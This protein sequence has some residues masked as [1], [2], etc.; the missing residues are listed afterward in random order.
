M[1]K[2]VFLSVVLVMMLALVAP[3]AVTVAQEKTKIDVWIAFQD[4]RLDWAKGVADKFNQMFP[5]YEVVVTGGYSYE[6]VFAQVAVAAEQGQL[7]AVVQFFEAG[8]QDARDSGLFKPI[9][10]ALGDRTEI[11]G[12]PV[13]FDDFVEP[14]RAYY[15]LDGK[16]TSMPWNTSSAIM[17]SNMNYLRAAGWE[18]PPATWDEV[19]AACEAIMALDNPPEYCFTWPNHGW[20]FEQW[21]AQQD[22]LY[23]NNGNGRE[24][25][26]TE[27]V[28]N[29][30]AG[31]AIL[32]WL[33]DLY[34]KGYLYYSGA[35]GGESWSTVDQAYSTQQ[36]AMAAYSSSD[37]TLYTQ[38]GIEGGFETVASFLPYND[39]TG[40]TGNL[41]GGA[42]LWLADGLDPAVE[43][44]ALTF[45]V[46]LTNTENAADWHKI[47]GYI[48]IRYSAYDLLE[49]EGWFE[50]WPNQT[51][52]VQQ[53]AQS[54][55]TPAT[56][57]ALVGGFPAIRNVVTAAIDRVLLSDDDPKAVLDE[58]VA[59]ANRIIEEY[60]LLN[61][62]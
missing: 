36:V 41:I 31:V 32:Q 46:Y 62:P 18:K 7:P 2:L 14:V 11:N 35:Q 60:N 38:M 49:A 21:L 12:L 47:T 9:A 29:S 16:W 3:G 19:E 54:K 5:Q 20:F 22:A 27:A 48:P 52:A 17:F 59:E 6:T 24:A 44:G 58:A 57:G 10:D 8:T 28:F 45:L 23:V 40:W 53:L 33:D 51:V 15:T 42:T 13:D 55:V 30:E 4:Y 61:A 37:T 39:D 56:S 1:K 25:R 34:N 50:Q 26:A 43:E